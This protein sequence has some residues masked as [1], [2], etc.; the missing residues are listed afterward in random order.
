M[1]FLTILLQ[2]ELVYQHRKNAEILT[3][4]IV[5]ENYITDMKQYVEKENLTELDLKCIKNI[6]SKNQNHYIRYWL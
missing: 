2:K 6:L 5:N 1:N 4:R 3:P